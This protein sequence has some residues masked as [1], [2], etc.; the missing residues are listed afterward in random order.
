MVS[1]RKGDVRDRF[2]ELL[3][4]YKRVDSAGRWLNNIGG[5][6]SDKLKFIAS[7]KFSI[8]F[9]NGSHPGYTTEKI[10]EPMLVDS[11]PIYWG[12]PLV[13]LDFNPRSFVNYYDHNSLDALVDWVI[14]LDRNDDLYCQHLAAV[15]SQ[16]PVQ[17][18]RSPR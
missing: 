10:F 9:E 3:S 8:A 5:T 15:V 18:V 12:N 4:K 7:Y 11:L 14:E 16:Q 17:P 6:V 13:N 2:F 1:N